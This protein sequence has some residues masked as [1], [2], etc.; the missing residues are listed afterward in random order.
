M[1]VSTH[2]VVSWDIGGS[3]PASSLLAQVPFSSG[4]AGEDQPGS[5]P[6]PSGAPPASRY[7]PQVSKE[8]GAAAPP[9][10]D[11]V[12]LIEDNRGDV[13]LILWALEIH[14][15]PLRVD[16][17]GD[18][19]EAQQYIQ[20]LD[21]DPTLPCPRMVLVD[22]NLPKKSGHEVLEWLRNSTR[23]R[24]IPAVVCTT[25]NA[26]A[27]REKASS[28]GAVHYFHKASS[29]REFLKIGEVMKEVLNLKTETNEAT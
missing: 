7:E 28:L 1:G 10:Q 15:L 16:V 12:L 13:Y 11:F 5:K 6:P 23:C 25:S 27:D 19:E 21:A 20:R 24:D 29:Y 22:L 3:V 17:V 14:K 8:T 4:L 9:D 26:P 18:G 2:G